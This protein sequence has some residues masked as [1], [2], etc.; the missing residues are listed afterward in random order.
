VLTIADTNVPFVDRAEN[1]WFNKRMNSARTPLLRPA[2]GLP[3]AT[4]SYSSAPLC[5]A[6]FI[7]RMQV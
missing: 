4:S 2:H 5:A 3:N 6:P 1:C 7:L